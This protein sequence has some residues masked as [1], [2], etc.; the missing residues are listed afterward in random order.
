[1][2]IVRKHN[3]T[4]QQ[5]KAWVDDKITEML[6]Q[7]GGS[8]SNVSHSWLDD[9]LVFA[10]RASGLVSFQGTL[11]VTDSHFYLD[12]PFPFLAKGF[13]PRAEA[14]ANKWLDDNL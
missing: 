12:L 13:E 14:E 4:K 3:F 6:H 5:A 2:Q 7:F 1:M 9:T 8:V 10:F 11:A